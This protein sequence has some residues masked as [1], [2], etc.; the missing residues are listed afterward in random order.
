MK[1]NIEEELKKLP[2]SPGVYIMHDAKDEIIYVGKAIVLKNRVRS[3][4]RKSTKK[5][6]KIE[7]MV[8]LI[9]RFEYIVTNSELEA[10]VLENNLI[11]EHRPKYNTMLK[12]DKTYPFIRVTMQNDYPK[13]EVSRRRKKDGAKYFGPFISGYSVKRTIDFLN[14]ACGLRN[15]N[16]KIKYGEQKTRPCLNYQLG[17]CSAPCRGTITKEEYALGVTKALQFLK[18]DDT[19]IIKDL[20]EKMEKSSEEMDFEKAAEYRDLIGSLRSI[21]QKQKMDH[22]S[23]DDKD[24]LAIAMDEKDVVVQVFFVRRGKLIGREHY[25]MKNA[26]G[27]K[28]SE[29]LATFVKQFYAGTTFVPRE[30]V[31]QEQIE[32]QEIIENWLTELRGRKAYIH[33]PRKGTK[34]K[35]VELAKENAELV[36]SKDRERIKANKRKTLGAVNELAVVLDMEEITRI[37]AYDISNTNGFES[38][39]SMVVFEEGK[40]KKSDYRKFKIKTVQGPDDYASLEEV[41]RR[42]FKHGLEERKRMQV[43]DEK[44]GSF[45]KFPSVIM[46]DGGK[47]QVHVAERVLEELKLSIPVCGMVKDDTHSTRGLYFQGEELALSTR[48]EGF[49]LLTRI[50]DEAHRFAIT[51]HRAI[52][53]KKQVY[54]ILDEIDGIG[55]ARRKSLLRMFGS[56][57]NIKEA[58][59]EEL[60]QADKMNEK[61]ANTVYDFFHKKEKTDK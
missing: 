38:V 47:G 13:L 21:T 24:I 15:C 45:T 2:A 7:R 1:F 31:L 5:S 41:L 51:Y 46:M 61:A 39:G 17:K 23:M 10:L 8:S 4:F 30:L 22:E 37:E 35:L 11:K 19:V 53:S 55:E 9:E 42:R 3:Y 18:G 28:K 16:V 50:Q 33:V 58:S 54:S 60:T 34:E 48:S 40:P 49:H 32:E 25:Y 57:A 20:T 43:E 52:R 36:L 12:D 14:Q 26:E 44:F 56:V 29:V 59:V 6:M 27:E